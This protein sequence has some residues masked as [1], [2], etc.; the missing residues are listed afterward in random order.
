MP[1]PFLGLYLSDR[2]CLRRIRP[3]SSHLLDSTPL[4]SLAPTLRPARIILSIYIPSLDPHRNPDQSRLPLRWP[5]ILHSATSRASLARP[6]RRL[7]PHGP[8]PRPGQGRGADEEPV[9]AEVDRE[10]YR[11]AQDAEEEEGGGRVS[12]LVR[13]LG[14]YSSALL[15]MWGRPFLPRPACASGRC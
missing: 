15:L 12:G 11:A 9:G 7:R 8:S 5:R 3:R 1:L 13:H 4:L 10:G 14:P 6:R 2:H